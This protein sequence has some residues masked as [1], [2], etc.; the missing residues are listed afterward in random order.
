M[1]SISKPSDGGSSWVQSTLLSWAPSG[2]LATQGGGRKAAFVPGG[3]SVGSCWPPFPAHLGAGDQGVSALRLPS[4]LLPYEVP[5]THRAPHR[6]DSAAP[7]GVKSPAS[8][9]AKEEV[10]G[11]SGSPFFPPLGSSSRVLSTFPTTLGLPR[12][13]LPRD[14]GQKAMT[15]C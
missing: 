2:S 1:A 3:H 10:G 12:H 5:L 4:C 15:E 7:P 9:P 6:S 8:V 14:K 13:T 11:T